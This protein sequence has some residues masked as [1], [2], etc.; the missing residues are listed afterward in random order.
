MKTMKT[1]GTM[2]TMKTTGT[3]KKMNDKDDKGSGNSDQ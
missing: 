3:M 2:E 1:T